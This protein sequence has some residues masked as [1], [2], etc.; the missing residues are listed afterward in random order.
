MQIA[1]S[2]KDSRKVILTILDH[3]ELINHFVGMAL[4]MPGKGWNKK[5]HKYSHLCGSIYAS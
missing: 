5:K 1:L 3:F 4:Q 2:I